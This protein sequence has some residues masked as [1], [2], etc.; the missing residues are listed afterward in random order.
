MSEART[1]PSLPRSSLRA[2]LPPDV[3]PSMAAGPFSYRK[4]HVFS[5][6]WLTRRTLLASVL[7]ASYAA[8]AALALRVSGTTWPNVIAM[9]V[10]FTA[11]FIVMVTGGPAIATWVRHRGFGARAEVCG[12]I[13]AVVLG[14]VIAMLADLWC[15]LGIARALGEKDLTGTGTSSGNRFDD[16]RM[17]LFVLASFFFHSAISGGVAS[18]SY[19]SERRR[20]RA[21]ALHLAVLDTDMK[22]AVLQAQIEPHFLFNTLA[23]IRPLI[24]QDSGK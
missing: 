21:R 18:F 15:S 10:Y 13:V 20:L 9:A 12:I 4:Y 5:L 1:P 24:R 7:I 22:L 2:P 16:A 23:S 14:F 6:P 11:G 8:L 17:S 3:V 19:F